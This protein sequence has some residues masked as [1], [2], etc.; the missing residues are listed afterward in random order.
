MFWLQAVPVIL[1]RMWLM[2]KKMN[3]VLRP[4]FTIIFL[5]AILRLSVMMCS[6]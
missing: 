4:L 3:R 2:F 5:P 6:L 1:A